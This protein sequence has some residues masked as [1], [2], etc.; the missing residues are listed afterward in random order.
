LKKCYLTQKDDKPSPEER[1]KPGESE[2]LLEF[3]WEDYCER[4]RDEE[5]GQ[6]VEA[7]EGLPAA[8][9]AGEGQGPT[10]KYRSRLVSYISLDGSSG[11]MMVK[12]NKTTLFDVANVS[13]AMENSTPTTTEKSRGSK[14]KVKVL[15]KKK[16]DP[17]P[18][19]MREGRMRKGLSGESQE[20]SS[21]SSDSN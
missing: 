6:K 14:K 7:D 13:M 4:M 11:R 18:K 16:N 19:S 8:A 20:I 21:S 10:G 1:K 2:T 9:A 12:E 3:E 15:R 5:E 17:N